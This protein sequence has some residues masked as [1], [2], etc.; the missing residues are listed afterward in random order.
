MW[1][2]VVLLKS[3]NFP[4]LKIIS[5]LQLIYLSCGNYNLYQQRR[6]NLLI[7]MKKEGLGERKYENV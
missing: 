7:S 2:S 5:K 1:T 3:I 6:Y 4:N